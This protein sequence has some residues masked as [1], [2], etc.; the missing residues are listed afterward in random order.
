MTETTLGHLAL[1]DLIIDALASYQ[2]VD[3]DN[4][5]LCIEP[6]KLLGSTDPQKEEKNRDWGE[7][8]LVFEFAYLPN[9]N[10]TSYL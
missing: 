5:W 7:S 3:G 4:N 6:M 1:E 2:P 10:F 8:A 9:I